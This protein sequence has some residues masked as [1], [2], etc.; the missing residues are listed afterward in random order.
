MRAGIEDARGLRGPGGRACGAVRAL[1]VAA[2]ASAT[3]AAVSIGPAV[4]DAHPEMSIAPTPLLAVPVA[5]AG[6][7]EIWGDDPTDSGMLT[8]PASLSGQA[9]SQVAVTWDGVLALTATGRVVGWGATSGRVQMIPDEV[10]AAQVAQIAVNS[11]GTY[12]AAVTTGGRVLAWGIKKTYPTPLSV[13]AALS[14]VVQVS[15]GQES[16]VALKSDGTV[17]AWGKPEDGLTQVPSGLVAT[18]VAAG[19]YS[20]IALT[21]QGTVVAWGLDG[22]RVVPTLPASVQQPGNVKAIAHD[23]S[24]A[25]AILADDSLVAWGAGTHVPTSETGAAPVSIVGGA[26]RMVVVDEEGVLTSW[27]SEVGPGDQA[28]LAPIPDAMDGRALAQ[29]SLGDQDNG[30]VLVTRLL[31]AAPPRISGAATV[32]SVLTATPG[33]FSASPDSVTGQWL[34]AGTPLAGATGPTLTV[35]SAM[36]GKSVVYRSTATKTGEEPVSSMSAAITVPAAGP[37]SS[38]V[39]VV[40]VA[41]TKKAAQLTLTGRVIASRAPT[42]KARVSIVKGKKRIV[43][44]TVPVAASGV[45]RLTIKKFGRLVLKKTGSKSKTGYRGSYGV[46]L[47]YLGNGQVRAAAARAT[48]KVKK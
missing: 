28:V 20:A 22:D 42:G 25:V 12:A 48:F 40:K 23:G 21:E 29:V 15:L 7:I 47:S 32:G 11:Q 17:V 1:L 31:R 24:R 10:A 14:G 9:V 18:A 35:T 45:L 46:T 27:G 34:L 19:D 3:L 8:V 37:V 16:A 39:R 38:T 5:Q 43:A 44:M 36:A 26:Q 33:T 41:A 13:P 30:A 6:A 2:L 4:A